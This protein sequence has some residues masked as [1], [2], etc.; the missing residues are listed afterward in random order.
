MQYRYLLA[1][2]TRGKAHEL[3]HIVAKLVTKENHGA[4]V[5]LSRHDASDRCGLKIV[6]L[7]TT[8]MRRL[9]H[10]ELPI[11]GKGGQAKL[12]VQLTI[13]LS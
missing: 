4:F 9:Q 13:I 5:I 12:Y 2:F 1:A 6:S 3:S 7:S 10:C 8:V 11:A